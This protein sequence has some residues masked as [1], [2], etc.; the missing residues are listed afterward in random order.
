MLS[1]RWL[2]RENLRISSRAYSC[3]HFFVTK[4]I[5]HTYIAHT[6]LLRSAST[7]NAHKNPAPVAALRVRA[8]MITHCYSKEA[9][10]TVRSS[11][12]WART[13]FK[14]VTC[15]PPDTL[16]LHNE[17]CSQSAPIVK[18][19][20]DWRDWRSVPHNLALVAWAKHRSG[21]LSVHVTLRRGS[22]LSQGRPIEL[23]WRCQSSPPVT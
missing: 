20:L 21:P 9:S 23:A 1:L 14:R 13:C 16:M 3:A 5:V 7:A 12:A 4:L 18:K 2:C 15:L 22:S 19:P 6:E 10:S 11:C 8:I 17:T